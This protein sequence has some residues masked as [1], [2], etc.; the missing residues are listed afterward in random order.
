MAKH[1]SLDR[2]CGGALL[3]R[4]TL[5][6]AQIGR[7]IMD[8]NTDPEKARTLT[9]KLKFKPD[10]GRRG[11]KTSIETNISLAPPMADET[12]M[13]IGQ[14]IRSGRIEISEMDDQNQAVSIPGETVPA[15]A[16]VIPT[17]PP[18]QAFNPETGEIYETEQ[19]KS[20]IDLRKANKKK[21]RMT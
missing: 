6:M 10:K 16:E 11:I 17:A 15:R 2:L 12:M 18:V 3:E 19:Q 20:P 13:L 4:F 14:D 7:N 8:P 9:I 5:A 1:I 21:E